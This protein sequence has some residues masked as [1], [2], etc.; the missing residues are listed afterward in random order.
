MILHKMKI[1]WWHRGGSGVHDPRSWGGTRFAF[2]QR[3]KSPPGTIIN[4]PPKI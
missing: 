2:E 4:W 3:F 1:T